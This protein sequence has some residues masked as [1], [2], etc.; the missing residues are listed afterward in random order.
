MKKFQS[1]QKTVSILLLIVFLFTS[2]SS[3]TLI[4]SEPS[5][6]KVFLNDQYVGTTP[7]KHTDKKIIFSTTNVRLEKEG[8]E[9]FFTTITKDEDAHVG[10]IIGG[11]F[12]FVPFLWALKY[13]SERNFLL[14]PTQEV[15]YHQNL[16]PVSRTLN[17]EKMD[18]LIKLKQ[19]L[20]DKIITV[21]EYE[22]ERKK[23]LEAY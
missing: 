23:I 22:R 19:L 17:K 1:T 14:R 7:H 2:C 13:D 6:A 10:A 21:E 16:Q 20:D 4:M 18:L 15:D 8:Y 12:V 11:I 9:P 5:G 3:S